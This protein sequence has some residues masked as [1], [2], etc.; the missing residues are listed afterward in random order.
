[1][2]RGGRRELDESTLAANSTPRLRVLVLVDGLGLTGGGERLARNLAV[3]L[4]PERFDRV[5]CITRWSDRVAA[6]PGAGEA[7]DELRDTGV[8]LLGLDR[9]SALDLAAWRPLVGRLRAGQVDILHAHKIGSNIWGAAWSIV[10]KPPVFIAHEQ[11]WSFEGNPARKLLDRELI[12]RRA[13]AFVCVSEEDRRRMIE[14]EGIDPAKIV[15]I[16]NGIP[17]LPAAERATIREELSIPADAPVIG[18]VCV[19]RDQKALDVLL[20]AAAEV[21]ARFPSAKVLIAGDG[22]MRVELERLRDELGLDDTVHFLGS[23]ADVPALLAGF[24]IAALSS[25]YEG[26]PL[27]MMEYMAAGLPIV[28]TRVGGVPE[29]IAHERT[30]LLVEPQA[31]SALAAELIRL[32]EEPATARRL[33]AAARER[34]RAEFSIAAVTAR[35]E[36]LYERLYAASGRR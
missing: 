23:R 28:A 7:I 24:D 16:P 4:D 32:L 21:H 3:H 34:Q 35:F 2:S 25:D 22:P 30:G 9:S 8:E 26:T 10:T 11:T 13:D 5:L 18:V 12:A 29:L 1:M 19:L 17:P 31:P 36:S 15:Y 14:I 6:E 27:A 33:G 20:R